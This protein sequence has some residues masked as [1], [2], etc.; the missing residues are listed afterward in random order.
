MSK[1][2][3]QALEAAYRQ[4]KTIREFE[5]R[6]HLEIQQGQIAGFTH[7]YSGQEAVAVGVCDHLSD[8]DLIASTH[9]GHGHCIAKGCDIVGMMKE[10][11]GRADGLCKGKGG[12]MHIADFDKGML[13][14]NAIVG[15][16]PPLATG[17]AIATRNA[18]KGHV[19]VSF[20]GDGSCNQGTVFEAMNLAVV[21]KLPT[22]FVFEDNG[23]S[24]HTGTDYAVGSKDIA[25]RCRGFGMPAA[26]VNG[27]DYFE[28]Y[29]GMREA[30][31]RARSGEGPSALECTTTRFFGHFEGDPQ[32][33]RAKGEVERHRAERDCLK[34]FEARVLREGWLDDASLRRIDA[35]VMQLIERAVHEAQAAAPPSLGELTTDVYASY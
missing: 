30:V 9:R 29:E 13:G 10:I 11:Y 21:L 17:A 32:R 33:Y 16:G 20:G 18:G 7:L 31:E 12:S 5:E 4:M 8:D 26:K 2:D 34:I 27:D 19:T 25:G 6:L 28:V 23:Y 3:T 35:E 22:I 14:A 1:P 24:E 15:G